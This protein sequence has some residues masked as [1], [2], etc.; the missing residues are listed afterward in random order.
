MGELDDALARAKPG[1][2]LLGLIYDRGSAVVRLPAYLHAHAYYQARRGGLAA[3]SFA[4][5]PKSPVRYRPG[6]EPPPFPPRFEWTPE[7]F[8]PGRH[9]KYFDYF[10]VRTRPGQPAPRL[11]PEG[12]PEAA[13]PVFEGP[14][15]KLYA[16]PAI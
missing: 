16:K 11:F 15:W 10:L 1:R 14:R 13:R 8:D 2:R 12:D 4:E 3:Y 9:G 7:A 5:L 6:L